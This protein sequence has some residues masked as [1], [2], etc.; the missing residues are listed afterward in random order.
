M[1]LFIYICV[2]ICVC[3]CVCVYMY[4]CVC[5][6]VCIR[7]FA[8]YLHNLVIFIMVLLGDPFSAPLLLNI[9]PPYTSYYWSIST[10]LLSYIH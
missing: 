7:K 10:C 9:D 5:V 8:I 1:Y 6:Y 2:C 4:M 3:L